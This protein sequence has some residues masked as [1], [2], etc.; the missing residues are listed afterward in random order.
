[1]KQGQDTLTVVLSGRGKTSL[2]PSSYVATGGEGAIYRIGDTI[3]KIYSDRKKMTGDRMEEKIRLLSGIR[4]PYIVAPRGLVTDTKGAL[5]GYYMDA[6]DGNGFSEVCA[7]AFWHRSGFT[8][9]DAC[10]LTDR[11]R[12]AVRAAHGYH[13]A[14][15]VD[16]NETNWIAILG[17][18]KGPEPRVIDVDSWAIGNWPA[19]AI[20]LSIKDWHSR[21]FDHQT[22]WFAWGVVSFQLFTG[23]HPYK[24]TL[25]GFKKG[26]LE[27]RMK[28]NASVFTPGVRLN[29]SVRDFGTIPGR[30]LDWYVETFQ[31]GERTVPPSPFDTGV[32][33]AKRALVKRILAAKN[34]QVVYDRLFSEP[35]ETAIRIFPCGVILLRSGRLIDLSTKKTV[36]SGISDV[37]E[38]IATADGWL[39]G[40]PKGNGTGFRFIHGK[41]SLKEDLASPVPAS[42]LLRFENRLFL[43]TERGLTEIRLLRLGKTLLTA[44]NTWGTMPSSTR[45]FDGVGIQDAFGA[46]YAIAPFGESG[47]AHV[48]IRELDGQ[49][50]LTAKAGERFLA[51]VVLDADGKYRKHEFA[52]D[53]TYGNYRVWTGEVDTADLNIAILPR[54][55]CATIVEDGELNILVPGSGDTRKISDRDIGT[56]MFL[57]HWNEKTV[58][59]RN[60]DVWQVRLK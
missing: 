60:G 6:I 2:P 59:M 25:D 36:D 54:G 44:G 9:D 5:I 22:D 19:K 33:T 27:G 55:V 31:H 7:P 51:V 15:M 23:T 24:G 17:G 53:K 12:D 45:W 56:D 41:T 42:G 43:K 46:T 8:R 3:V 50:T 35:G 4:H 26:D 11:M 1:M 40:N 34:A 30:L 20:M 58:Y 57:E 47:C 37:A 18:Q 38:V 10:T 21:G 32:A 49:K 48:R 28:Q 16:P 13:D 29:Q 39:I 14:V 52:F